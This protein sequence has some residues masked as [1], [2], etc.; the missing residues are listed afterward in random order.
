MDQEHLAVAFNDVDLCLKVIEAG[1]RN[2]LTPWAQLYHFES[3][4]RGKD[5]TVEKKERFKREVLFM[6][7]KWGDTLQND[8]YYSPHLTL[9][10]EQFQIRS[11]SEH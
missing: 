10:Y 6:K 9:Q 5:D 1:Y 7:K 2:L 11:K 3:K 8:P 4:S